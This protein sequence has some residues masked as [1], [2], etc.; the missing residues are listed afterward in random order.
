MPEKGKTEDRKRISYRILVS[1]VEYGI[2]KQCE[3]EKGVSHSDFI[4]A[5]LEAFTG[6]KIFKPR[7]N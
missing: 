6:R 4:R 5:A 7:D 1:D 2:L 3:T